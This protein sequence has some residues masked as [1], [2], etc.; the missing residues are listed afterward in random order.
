V[1]GP[2]AG[3]R[4]GATRAGTCQE[5]YRT[6]SA[7]ALKHSECCRAESAQALVR[8]GCKVGAMHGSWL[9]LVVLGK[10]DGSHER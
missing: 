8:T 10:R 1:R 6:G 3:R 7:T 5:A 4:A 9:L 2:L